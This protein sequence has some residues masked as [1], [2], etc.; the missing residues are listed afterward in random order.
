M[1]KNGRQPESMIYWLEEFTHLFQS[2]DEGI[3]VAN[4]SYIAKAENL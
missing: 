1:L 3:Y 4:K 2:S